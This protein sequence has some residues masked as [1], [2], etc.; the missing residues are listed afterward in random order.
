MYSKG[1]ILFTRKI[2]SIIFLYFIKHLT[3]IISHFTTHTQALDT[4]AQANLNFAIYLINASCALS[5]SLSLLV[6]VSR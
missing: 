1:E 6:H 2:E 5:I 4:R 3:C